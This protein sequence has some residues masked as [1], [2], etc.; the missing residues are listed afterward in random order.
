M[1]TVKSGEHGYRVVAPQSP[2][3]PN[4]V[5]RYAH[6]PARHT[7]IAGVNKLPPAP[8]FLPRG[9]T[10][11]I[12]IVIWTGTKWFFVTVVLLAGEKGSVAY[13]LPKVGL[14]RSVLIRR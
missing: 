1:H 12:R 2:V 10:R 5:L 14:E 4:D 7:G 8:V 13:V 9:R 6:D 3:T 11:L